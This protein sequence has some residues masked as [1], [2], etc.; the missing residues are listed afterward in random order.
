LLYHIILVT[1][2]SRGYG[3]V[4]FETEKDCKKAYKVLVKTLKYKFLKI[5]RII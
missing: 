4:E 5:Q 3:F 2:I 1:G